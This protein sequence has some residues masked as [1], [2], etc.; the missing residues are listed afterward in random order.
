MVDDLR[1]LPHATLAEFLSTTDRSPVDVYR[2]QDYSWTRLRRDAGRHVPAPQDGSAEERDLLRAVRRLLHIDDPERVAAYREWLAAAT[3]PRVSDM[4]AR[5]RRLLLMLHYDVWGT[6]RT[7]TDLDA[8]LAT[9]WRYETVREELR[10]LLGV[11]DARS[12]TLTRPSS[13][14]AE[15]PLHVHATYTRDEILGA[16]GEGSPAR[17]PQFRE[18]VRHV[19]GAATDLLLITLHKAQRDYSPTT[20]Y[21]DYAISPSRFHWESQSTQSAGSPTIQRYEQHAARDHTIV[22]FVRE[23]RTLET[24]VGSP[25]V[26]LGPAQYV[27]S[28]GSR[29]VSF[30][31][32]LDVPMPEE[33]FETARTVA[34]A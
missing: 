21:R 24:G 9:L 27:S 3:P 6:R 30:T 7:F 16:Y 4:D 32:A 14:A 22:L 1:A 15:I 13:L 19:P 10:D 31:W 29:P 12:T 20:L 23:R 5:Q 25:Y 18:G 11:L 17:P 28:T 33:L 26:C 2:R 8:S 34:A